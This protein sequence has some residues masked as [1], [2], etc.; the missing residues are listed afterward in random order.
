[1][2]HP[3]MGEGPHRPA[4]SRSFTHQTVTVSVTAFCWAL[5]PKKPCALVPFPRAGGLGARTPSS[6]PV[7]P[8]SFQQQPVR[9]PS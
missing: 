9:G 4:S 3:H 7:C 1:M 5:L 8:Q 6:G 2:M